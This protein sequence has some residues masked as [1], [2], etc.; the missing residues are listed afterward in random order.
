MMNNGLK[1]EVNLTKLLQQS[2]INPVGVTN[3]ETE[4]TL[5]ITG[6]NTIAGDLESQEATIRAR[7]AERSELDAKLQEL[8][9]MIN[10]ARQEVGLA[11]VNPA[12]KSTK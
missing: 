9:E 2:M 12:V 4:K 5:P 8:V 3:P 10:Q 1:D 6:L 7:N 11:V